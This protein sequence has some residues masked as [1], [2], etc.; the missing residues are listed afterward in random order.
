LLQTELRQAFNIQRGDIADA[1]EIGFGMWKL[2]SL[3]KRKGKDIYVV[4][5]MT[6]DDPAST[7]SLQFDVEK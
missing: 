5:N 7:V 4:P 1:N 6:Y 2:Q 3:F